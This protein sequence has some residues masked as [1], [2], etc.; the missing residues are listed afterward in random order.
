[1]ATK[2]SKL[3]PG[4]RLTVGQH[5]VTVEKY[6]SEGGFAQIYQCRI[7]PIEQ[8]SD[9]AC[10][11]RVIVP[12]K[13][14]LTQ[15]RAEVEVMQKLSGCDEIVKYY[16]SH[17]S[18]IPNSAS[19]EVYVL[20]EL[21]AN[22]SLL[23]FMNARLKTK[24]VET[25]IL[26]ILYDVSRAVYHMHSMGLIHRDIKIE[27]VLIDAN[28]R[29]KLC[30]FGST[31]PPLRVPKTFQEFQLLNNDILHQTT[32]QYRAPEMIDLYQLKPI[33]DK[34]DIWALGI[35]LYKLCY[36]FTPFEHIGG[37]FAIL[38]A[39]YQFSPQPI[40]SKNLLSLIAGMLQADLNERPNIYQIV[41]EVSRQLNIPK[42]EIG[43]KDIFGRGEYKFSIELKPQSLFPEQQQ[44]MVFQ[45]DLNTAGG[46]Y[47]RQYVPSAAQTPQPTSHL[48]KVSSRSEDPSAESE[49]EENEKSQ[50]HITVTQTEV[51]QPAPQ[52]EARKLPDSQP[53]YLEAPQFHL[54]N[55]SPDMQAVSPMM[56][57]VSPGLVASQYPEILLSPS[58]SPLL[59]PTV[60]G[61]NTG[62]FYPASLG[63]RPTSPVP[64]PHSRNPFPIAGS[65]ADYAPASNGP[66]RSQTPVNVPVSVS[67]KQH[68]HSSHNS[69]FSS[70]S[71]SFPVP[72][73]GKEN[74]GDLID[75]GE[76]D[77]LRVEPK[78]DSKHESFVQTPQE[79]SG[80]T[81]RRELSR[82]DMTK[83]VE[84]TIEDRDDS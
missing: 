48:L 42:E 35:F 72:T 53:A 71:L 15:L 56:I 64:R 66:I 58:A 82:E 50:G 3:L 55:A 44:P 78:G 65:T 76:G 29:F 9:I 57:P 51:H 47:H 22:K 6:I 32:P 84:E 26:T 43:L 25:E 31:S 34:A 54:E 83:M 75:F 1:M 74:Y 52:Q 10:L 33:G 30:D 80:N 67:S 2:L 41:V 63:S 12:D 19:Y 68:S 17:A 61:V 79:S 45:E 46:Y 40:Y 81:L 23:D 16:D 5:T 28:H 37:E 69:Q 77:T 49:D 21:C 8:G 7:N 18:R 39:C 4:T 20:M 59:G 73:I 60:V 38:H 24:L 14:G 13:N 11:K 36:Y 70:T 27:N 62:D